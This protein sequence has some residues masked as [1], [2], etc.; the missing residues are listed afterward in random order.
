MDDTSIDGFGR[1]KCAGV[2]V[3]REDYGMADLRSLQLHTQPPVSVESEHRHTE[4]SADQHTEE[5]TLPD[6]T[7][8]KSV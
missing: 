7:E 4:T 2:I 8:L 1:S 3:W 5:G 6:R